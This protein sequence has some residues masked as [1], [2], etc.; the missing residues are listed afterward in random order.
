LCGATQGANTAQK[1]H[2]SA[3]TAARMAIGEVRK[4]YQT[5][6]S[7]RRASAAMVRPLA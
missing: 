1:V 3:I 2:S 5:S 7:S 6:L 4:L